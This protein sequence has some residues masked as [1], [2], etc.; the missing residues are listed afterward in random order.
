M[1]FIYLFF[2][3]NIIR[4]LIAFVIY[5]LIN[6]VFENINIYY[7]L[8]IILFLFLNIL[9]IIVLKLLY[10]KLKIII[11]IILFQIF[12]VRLIINFNC[13]IKKYI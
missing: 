1:T 12:W 5:L 13:F 4:S 3:D 6:L 7:I 11:I 8:L 2:C 9:V 10:N